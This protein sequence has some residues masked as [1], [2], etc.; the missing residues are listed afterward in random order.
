MPDCVDCCGTGSNTGSFP[1]PGDPD[2]NTSVLSVTGYMDS[3]IV[4]WSLPEVSLG[5]HS[6]TVIYR[7]T[8]NDVGTST[9]I[10]IS[11]GD[12][13]VDETVLAGIV[14][15]Y[16]IRMISINGTVGNFI[17]PTSATAPLFY[18][19]LNNELV[20][21]ID[22]DNFDG[23]LKTEIARI[24]SIYNDLLDEV[25]N[26]QVSETALSTAIG[27]LD[28][29]YTGTYAEVTNK[30]FALEN[31]HAALAGELSRIVAGT[32]ETF[33][34]VLENTVSQADVD[35][36]I[37]S[38]NT[39]LLSTVGSTYA[40]IDDVNSTITGLSEPGGAIHTVATDLTAV[41]T[42]V[43]DT[44]SSI[45]N[46]TQSVNGVSARWEVKTDVNDLEGGVGFY[47]DGTTTKFAINATE[48]EANTSI[49][50]IGLEAG[51]TG[52]Q[53]GALAIGN[54][55]GRTSQGVN[56]V[57]IGK[58][59]GYNTQAAQA[60][61]IGQSAGGTNQGQSAV[62]IGTVAGANTQGMQSIAIGQT[63]GYTSQGTQSVAIGMD[64]GHTSQG[65]QSVAIGYRAGKNGPQGSGGVAIG[66]QANET[67]TGDLSVAIGYQSNTYTADG[68]TCVGTNSTTN[69]NRSVS[70]GWNA[71][72][73]GTYGVCVGSNSQ[74]E[75]T[76]SISIGYNCDVGTDG[77]G[78][79]VVGYN[80]NSYYLDC[81]VL[82][83]NANST[84]TNQFVLGY[85]NITNLR[86]NDTSISSL[87]DARDKTEIVDCPYGIDY[88]KQVRPVKY[89]WDYRQEHF[90]DG[91]A[92][93]KQ[94]TEEVG[95][96]AQDLAALEGL[97]GATSLKSYQHYP[98]ARD[99]DDNLVH[100]DLYEADALKLFPVLVK[101]VQE[102]QAMIEELQAQVAALSP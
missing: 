68:A 86:C 12:S 101:A 76:G 93:P 90:V 1:V 84:G 51:L 99:V 80:A 48:L 15:Y 75:G 2:L 49:N 31:D 61:A 21:R 30:Q 58:D 57:A 25:T 102:Q 81:T 63:A 77:A 87:S 23:D 78:S 43:D 55:S 22:L 26:R 9:Q 29:A 28:A 64:A 6:K 94:G 96:I 88:I 20:G 70:V 59:A 100:P 72:T 16:W 98:E 24:D 46:L 45:T 42:R 60:V 69:G 65:S 85:T 17:G 33:A 35:S 47:N 39:Q 83:K 79:T 52:Q 3:L 74:T 95:F 82:G 62:A 38:N 73:I 54:Y 14:Y 66:W 8:E 27:D 44:E 41:T 50:S 40:T 92:P 11:A 36:A 56:A 91:V 53:A 37:A 67:A 4:R 7:S 10:G 89:K 32:D 71:H 34:T 19:A 13:Y 5:A 18:D 97:T